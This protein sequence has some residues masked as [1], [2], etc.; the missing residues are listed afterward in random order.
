MLYTYP[1]GNVPHGAQGIGLAKKTLK[2][3]REKIVVFLAFCETQA[4]TQIPDVNPDL[5]RRGRR[6]GQTC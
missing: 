4:V 5:L 1:A 3:Y 2:D 6:L